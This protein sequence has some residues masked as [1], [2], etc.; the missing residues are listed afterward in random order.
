[1]KS[2]N[3]QLGSAHTPT[4]SESSPTS[5]SSVGVEDTSPTTTTFPAKVTPPAISRPDVERIIANAERPALVPLYNPDRSSSNYY[6]LCVYGFII[7][8][9]KLLEWAE[10]YNILPGAPPYTRVMS[11]WEQRIY[12]APGGWPRTGAVYDREGITQTCVLIG[13]NKNERA[14]K[15]TQNMKKIWKFYEWFGGEIIPGWYRLNQDV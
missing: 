14:R 8:D 9:E 7:T 11:A 10:R 5:A 12:K 1:M 13:S 6:P 2:P 15:A 4:S 3:I